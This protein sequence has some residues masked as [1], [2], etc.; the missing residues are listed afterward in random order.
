MFKNITTVFAKSSSI[1]KT[2]QAS[3]KEEFL[4]GK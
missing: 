4:T 2:Q 1:P 3:Y